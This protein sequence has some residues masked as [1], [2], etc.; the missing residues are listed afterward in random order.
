MDIQAVAKKKYKATTD[1]TYTQLV[2]ENHLN[3]DFTPGKPNKYWVADIT[4]IKTSEGWLY[5]A[6]IMDLFSQKIIG[7]SLIKRLTKELGIATLDIVLKQRKLP[8]DL[9]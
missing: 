6:I 8:A 1:S 9:I 5:L 3:R 4:Y 2:A 7:W